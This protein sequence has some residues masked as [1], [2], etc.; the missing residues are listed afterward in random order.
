MHHPRTQRKAARPAVLAPAVL[1]ALTPGWAMAQAS[2]FMTGATALQSNIL[3][4]LTPIAIILVMVIGGMAMANRVAQVS[5]TYGQGDAHTIV[6]N[7]R[8]GMSPVDAGMDA[9]HRI[10]RNYN[11]DMT[12]LKFMDMTY[13]IL[14][15]DGAYAGVSL[16]EGYS[17]AEKHQI[18]VHDGTK[19]SEVTL[20]LFKGYSHDFPPFPIEK[21]QDLTKDS[22]YLK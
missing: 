6:E 15:K 10:V 3:A 9:L 18:V 17:E 11:N 19:R 20:A 8:H 5:S 13:Y 2:P 1:P 12:K 22:E 4:W 14:R 21:P 7:M 16:W